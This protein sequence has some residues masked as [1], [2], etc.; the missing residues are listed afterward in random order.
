MVGDRAARRL[1]GHSVR[2]VFQMAGGLELMLKSLGLNPEALT[3][4]SADLFQQI[5][6]FREGM[7]ALNAKQDLTNATLLRIEN[8]LSGGLELPDGALAAMPRDEL[9]AMINKAET[10]QIN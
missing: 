10:E 9:T 2:K 5:S 4:Y 6:M 7:E 8:R 3:K 1:G